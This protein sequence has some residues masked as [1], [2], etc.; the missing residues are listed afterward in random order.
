MVVSEFTL[1]RTGLQCIISYI[2][3]AQNSGVAA[4]GV[5]H[6]PLAAMLPYMNAASEICSSTCTRQLSNVISSCRLEGLVDAKKR[7]HLR[8]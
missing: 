2:T 1:T 4:S 3:G 5:L 7:H 6:R 8:Q